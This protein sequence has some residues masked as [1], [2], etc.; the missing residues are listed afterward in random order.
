MFSLLA[1]SCEDVYLTRTGRAWY[2]VYTAQELFYYRR[3]RPQFGIH[4]RPRA[5]TC[6][7]IPIYSSSALSGIVCR[8]NDESQYRCV[9]CYL[10][11]EL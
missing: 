8:R 7:R 2:H 5:R 9:E 11:K 6:V 4:R 3:Q 1:I 10:G